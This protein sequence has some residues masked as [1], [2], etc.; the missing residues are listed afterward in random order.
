M[1]IITGHTDSK[2]ENIRTYS[3]KSSLFKRY[4]IVTGSTDNGILTAETS[5]NIITYRIDGITFITT[6]G[7]NE[8][9]IFSFGSDGITGNTYNYKIFKNDKKSSL[10]EN[11]TTTGS[12][13]MD[14]Q[15]LSIFE[16]VYRLKDIS[17]L[18][19]LTTYGGGK[20]F[21]IIKNI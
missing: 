13:T 9:T 18:R 15:E 19:R 5:G 20:V 16:M 12:V 7:T 8:S 4:R 14:R 1:Y 10:S 17:T 2:L 11:I 3:T 21:N 6:T